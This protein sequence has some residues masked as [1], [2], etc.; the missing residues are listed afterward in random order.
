[1]RWE[2]IGRGLTLAALVAS[3]ACVGENQAARAGE[4]S[5]TLTKGG[6]D[7][8]G[9]YEV[10]ERFWKPAPEHD[11][12]WSWGSVS[13]VAVDNPD[14]IFVAVWGDQGTQG[15]GERPDGTN[16]LVV[17]D[18]NGN[19]TENWSRWDSLF[20]RPHQVYISPYDPERHVWVVERGGNGVHEQIL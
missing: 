3:S 12:A 6:D 18:G 20:N 16:Y 19:V 8:T 17:V 11:S 4:G 5:G 14:R 7:R 2:R 9:P 10:V 13:G 15:Q 1:M